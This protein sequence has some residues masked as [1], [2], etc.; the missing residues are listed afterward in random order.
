MPSGRARTVPGDAHH[1][2][3]PEISGAVHHALDDPRVVAQVDEGEVLPVLAPA[4][5]PTADGHDLALVLGPQLP[6]H[7]RAH[8]LAH[9]SNTFLM[10]STTTSRSTAV[11]SPDSRSRTVTVRSSTSCSPTMSASRAEERP[12]AFICAFIER[13]SKAR[14]ADT[15]AAPQRLGELDRGAAVGDVD[16]EG[17]DRALGSREDA[18]GIAREQDALDAGAEPHAGSGRT[19]ELLDE[20]VVAAAAE[21]RGLR[22]AE[23][24]ALELEERVRVVVDAADEGLVDLELDA[25]ASAGPACTRSPWAMDAASRWSAIRGA[26][27]STVRVTS[28][29]ES[30]TRSG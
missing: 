7:V 11:W 21:E 3:A 27:T 20:A 4:A 9:C 8:G 14:S 12:A 22:V 18:F 28:R 24:G 5:H 19:S 29:L 25:R 10:W 15:P 16:H 13:P 26:S 1:E 30:S 23:R 2:L 17:V 6:A